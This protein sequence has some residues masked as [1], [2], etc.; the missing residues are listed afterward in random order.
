VE[1]YARG[2]AAL[3]ATFA[4]AISR[5]PVSLHLE[6]VPKLASDADYLEHFNVAGILRAGGLAVAQKLATGR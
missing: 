4:A 1:I 3:W 2:D 6:S 5:I